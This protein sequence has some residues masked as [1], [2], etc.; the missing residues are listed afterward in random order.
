LLIDKYGYFVVWIGLIIRSVKL[1]TTQ[2][3]ALE[4]DMELVWPMF[5]LRPLKNGCRFRSVYQSLLESIDGDTIKGC[6]K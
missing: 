6:I 3:K 5:D 4:F 1:W 2:L